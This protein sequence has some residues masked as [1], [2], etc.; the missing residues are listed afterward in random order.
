LDPPAGWQ[1]RAMGSLAKE[2]KALETTEK[3]IATLALSS[4]RDALIDRLIAAIEQDRAE[5][6]AS[7]ISGDALHREPP[8]LRKRVA[9][10]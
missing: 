2:I 6:L 8:R 5:L 1:M 7:M 3:V 10:H 9:D 4:E